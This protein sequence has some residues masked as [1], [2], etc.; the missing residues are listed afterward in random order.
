MFLCETLERK[1]K[2]EWVRK[3]LG[4]EGLFVVEPQGRSGG[5]ALLWKKNDQ[6]NLVSFSQNHIDVKVK[7]ADMNLWRLTGFYGEPNRF[8]RRKTWDL[9][10]NLA[11]DSNL[12]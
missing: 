7:V 2:I 5:L 3:R 6:V 10:R 1:N 11:R 4:F 12:P 8:Q 9:L